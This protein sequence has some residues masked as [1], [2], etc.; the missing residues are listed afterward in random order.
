MAR[1]VYGF[2]ILATVML[3]ATISQAAPDESGKFK[4]LGEGS[5]SCGQWTQAR[6]SGNS[7]AMVDWLQGFITAY[8][9]YGPGPADI[10][11]GIDVD[12][13]REW[14]DNYCAQY[15]LASIAHAAG[16]FIDELTARGLWLRED[17][18]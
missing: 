1:P 10:S 14:L 8:N 16:D 12:G 2:V 9:R 18:P 11:K 7:G 5:A 4:N 3:S 17:V 15:P 13:F 6:D